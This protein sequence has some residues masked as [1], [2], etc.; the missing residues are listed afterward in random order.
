MALYGDPQFCVTHRA[1]VPLATCH[2]SDRIDQIF[3]PKSKWFRKFLIKE[4][5]MTPLVG[6]LGAQKLTYALL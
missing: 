6:H 2:N 3:V 4:L 1:G 5:H